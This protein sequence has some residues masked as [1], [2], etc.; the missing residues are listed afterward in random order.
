[1]KVFTRVILD[2]Y[3]DQKDVQLSFEYLLLFDP[4]KLTKS[5]EQETNKI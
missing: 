3:S 2:K 4:M 5:I 1:M